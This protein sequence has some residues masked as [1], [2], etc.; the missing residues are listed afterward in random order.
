MKSIK[1]KLFF[2]LI[3]LCSNVVATQEEVTQLATQYGFVAS[4]SDPIFDDN[5]L[6]ALNYVIELNLPDAS[7][8]VGKLI[9]AGADVNLASKDGVTPL[10]NAIYSKNIDI[11]IVN[12][13]IKA[14][15]KVNLV[16]KDGSTPL[17]NAIYVDNL[18]IVNALIKAKANVNLVAKD[19]S[20][21]LG[22]A[23]YINILDIYSNSLD[24]VKAL[25]KAGANV[26][27]VDKDG[28]TPLS[29]ATYNGN[30]KIVQA[31][32]KAG[33]NVN[34]KDKDGITPL[35]LA[36]YVNNLEMVNALIKAKAKIILIG[37]KKE[38]YSNIFTKIDT[39][40]KKYLKFLTTED[41]K[42]LQDKIDAAQKCRS[43][44]E[45]KAV[46]D[47]YNN[48]LAKNISIAK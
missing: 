9:K 36:V 38:T 40:F 20:T 5:G 4:T 7:Q 31:L 19:G 43:K 27:L 10:L 48:Y 23:I 32:I 22:A 6:T 39:S 41:Q 42:P 21:P 30:L 47:A 29:L 1:K 18:D 16:A 35:E 25:I 26:N 45:C 15:A 11:V 2:S 44:D 13:L 14:G 12:A 17:F 37:G 3:F 24:I 34:Y 28:S 8:E 46:K 33:A